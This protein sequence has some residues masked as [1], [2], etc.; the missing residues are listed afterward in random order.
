MKT[1]G[2]DLALSRL[3]LIPG[4][5]PHVR[6]VGMP[7]SGDPA[8]GNGVSNDA[9]PRG[10]S[11]DTNSRAPSTS[12]NPLANVTSSLR[13]AGTTVKRLGRK[14]LADTTSVVL[15]KAR[16][17][18]SGSNKHN[19]NGWDTNDDENVAISPSQNRRSSKRYL[20]L[21]PL[22]PRRLRDG[23]TSETK[24]KEPPEGYVN[25]W[26]GNFRRWQ[27]RW[28]VATVPGV[29]TM[30]SR[31][32]KLGPSISIDLTN[33]SVLV[34]SNPEDDVN[35]TTRNNHR[36]KESGASR[37]FLVVTPDKTYRIRALHSEARPL[38]VECVRSSAAKLERARQLVRARS[39]AGGG[40]FI[41]RPIGVR[42]A[43]SGGPSRT[44]I[45]SDGTVTPSGSGKPPSG[46]KSRRGGKE[47]KLNSGTSSNGN[48]FQQP[49]HKESHS[50]VS[51]DLTEIKLSLKE[52]FTGSEQNPELHNARTQCFSIAEASTSSYLGGLMGS[53]SSRDE[54]DDDGNDSN[55]APKNVV[56][57]VNALNVAY[58]ST[59]DTLLQKLALATEA[60]E[61]QRVRST[62][63]AQ[64]LAEFTGVIPSPG[65]ADAQVHVGFGGEST[66]IVT[67]GQSNF[68]EALQSQ[69]SLDNE[70]SNSES[71]DSD[72]DDSD[73]YGSVLSFATGVSG[74]S[75]GKN[76]LANVDD[77][78]LLVAAEVV[79]R[80]DFVI[81]RSKK[82]KHDN[83]NAEDGNL[84]ETSE[85]GNDHASSVSDESS[86]E[87]ED[88]D[89]TNF[90]P[91]ERLPA[92]QPLNQSFSLWSILKQ[93]MGKDLSRISMPANINQPLSLLQRTVEDF[94]YIDLLYEAIDCQGDGSGSIKS[95]ALYDSGSTDRVALLAAFASSSYASWYGRAQKPFASTLGETYDW[96]SADGLVKVVCECVVYDPPVAAFHATG[97]TPK[98]TPFKIHGEGMGT[99]KFYGRY[100]QVNVKG[101]L[102]L[103]LPN[104]GEKYSWCKAA[105][106]VHN[107]ISGRVW[108]DMVG[109][110]KVVAHP[111]MNS[112]TNKQVGGE[113]ASFKLLKGSKPV[114][115]KVDT[116]GK[117]V[118]E[119]FDK[120]GVKTGDLFGNCLE[121]VYLTA[122]EGY[123]GSAPIRW[124]GGGSG[125]TSGTNTSN[126][127][128]TSNSCIQT[129]VWKFGGLA[130][131]SSRQYGFTKFAIALNEL[132]PEGIRNLPPTDS[133][134][135]PDMRALE[136][137]EPEEAS[138][139]KLR[140]EDK[141]RALASVRRKKE[142]KYSTTWF[143]K[144]VQNDE[145]TN[146]ATETE[147]SG[148]VSYPTGVD[149][150]TDGTPPSPTPSSPGGPGSPG[151][152]VSG[153]SSR[154]KLDSKSSL[155]KKSSK[156]GKGPPSF[157]KHCNTLENQTSLWVY[158]G[159]YWEQRGVGEYHAPAL[160]D[161]PRFDVFGLADVWR[162]ERDRRREKRVSV[163]TEE[164]NQLGLQ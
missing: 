3:P 96:T 97:T 15:P 155:G 152:S 158:D 119:I 118:G 134:F 92:P 136:N 50:S 10:V 130:P 93:S 95:G 78:D 5:V 13:R 135:R 138:A 162:Q 68:N 131:D 40:S 66:Q 161:D 94:E 112:K 55:N 19:S 107:V 101:G 54:A 80:H 7:P 69:N 100:V 139:A 145:E 46:V 99:S 125:V 71:D 37:Q 159:G 137:G 117:M 28:M 142:E 144:R 81:S 154:E 63:L 75:F 24:S 102:H 11:A 143:R 70:F 109:E 64:A 124:I 47:L 30:H 39:I 48:T 23:P 84:S 90:A 4:R 156:K 148:D 61:R 114:A 129:P 20:D 59:I 140:V 9:D 133:R 18:E 44:S 105:M 32:S 113:S 74:G 122:V 153:S 163:L 45:G 77:L 147:T 91:R 103:E 76:E 51:A 34:A 164:V 36:S 87:D 73:A 89:E 58:E 42:S 72:S 6:G 111:V 106:H 126:T 49:F 38:W 12:G 108:V 141:N 85:N 56:D 151:G 14:I 8:W 41:K 43:V 62:H 150:T 149:D 16:N 22:D 79:N 60:A 52:R 35:S 127:P 115:N 83:V 67:P 29:L 2:F 82:D 53:F 98:G 21:G 27:K 120:H 132:T 88:D 65:G 57:A 26:Q 146:G 157:G 123:A 160:A 116:R 17:S 1:F 86:G 128:Q 110:V 25:V 104:T 121:E 31:S 33:A